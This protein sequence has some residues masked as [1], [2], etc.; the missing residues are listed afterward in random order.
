MYRTEFRTLWEK[1]RVGCF[2]RTPSK[3]VYYLGWNRSPAQAGCMRQVLGPGA[4][5][6]LRGIEWR[7]RWERG[8][9][10]GIHVNP[11]LIHVNVWQKPLQY[12]K[13]ISLQLIKINEKKKRKGMKLG[14]Y[15]FWWGLSICE[16]FLSFSLLFPF[17]SLSSPWFLL[18]VS[19]SHKVHAFFILMT[20][21]RT[22]FLKF[23]S[24]S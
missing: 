15:C 20:T 22:W 19:L 16:M 11:W 14:H 1:A 13:V 18:S 5:G 21:L 17:A 24:V 8:L 12:C 9:G 4:L 23:T 7:G 6:R 2:E 10:W 3:H